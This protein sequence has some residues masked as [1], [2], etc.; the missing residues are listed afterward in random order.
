MTI[1]TDFEA[2][3]ADLGV[4]FEHGDL[5]RL[6][7]FLTLMLRE[8]ERMNLTAITDEATAWERHV[9]DSLTLIGP[10]VGAEA[11]RVADLGS[12]GGFPGIPLAICLPEVDFTLIEATGK[13][14]AFLQRA[15]EALGLENARVVSERAE[16]LGQQRH[17]Y[18]D[19]FDVV[20]ARAVGR[21]NTLVE[22]SIPLARV[23]GFVFAV[24]GARA[25]E[26]IEEAKAA[27]HRLHAQVVET[28]ESPTGRVV[29]LQKNRTTPRIYPRRPGEPKRAPLR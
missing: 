28:I 17:D 9:L 15:I 13:K 11:R 21:L 26:E 23:G 22:L 24:K 6:D 10:L 2:R 16:T 12:G 19:R 8:N 29:I 1:P 3:A 5:D 4:A 27:L 7:Q 18:R 25:P 20:V 14:A